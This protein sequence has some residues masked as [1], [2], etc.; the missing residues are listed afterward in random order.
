MQSL[1][2][3]NIPGRMVFDK[4]A[5]FRHVTYSVINVN[6]LQ[7]GSKRYLP[8]MQAE[9]TTTENTFRAKESKQMILQTKLIIVEILNV[10][11][12]HFINLQFSQK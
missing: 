1:Y 3:A 8:H 9:S 2:S 7:K 4:T 11:C 10:S 12:R 6:A 5:L